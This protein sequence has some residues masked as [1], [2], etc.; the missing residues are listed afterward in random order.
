MAGPKLDIKKVSEDA[1]KELRE[2]REKE[3]KAQIKDKLKELEDAKA[4]VKNVERELED[5]Y[6]ELGE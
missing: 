4:V 2:E 3:A 5:L 6:A 1:K